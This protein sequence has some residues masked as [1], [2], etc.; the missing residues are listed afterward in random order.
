M[1][2]FFLVKAALLPMP[3]YAAGL[4]FGMPAWG[5]A[6]GLAYGLAWALWRHRGAWPPVFE[7]AQLVG[8]ALVLGVHLA[9]LTAVTPF[10]NAIVLGALAVGSWWS[11]AIDRP[12]TAGFSISD[13]AAVSASPIF[14]MVNRRISWLWAVLF[15]WFALASA[16]KLPGAFHYGPLVFGGLATAILQKVLVRRALTRLA[17]DAQCNAWPAPAFD[18]PAIPGP[19]EGETCD[20]AVVGAG[21][22]GLTAAALLARAGLRVNVYEQHVAA[23]GFCHGWLRRARD[24]QTGQRLLFRFDSGV[25]DVSGWYK[26]G[27]VHTLFLRLG[28]AGDSQWSRVHHRYLIDG[29]SLDI[30][31]DWHAYAAALGARLPQDAAGIAALFEDVHQIHAAMF[32][33]GRDRSGIPGMP[34]TPEA[35]MAFARAHPKA[36]AWMRRPWNDLVASYVSSDVARRWISALAG[37]VTDDAGQLTVADMVPIFGYYFHGGFYPQGGSG[38][39][40]DS[41]VRCIEA[42]GGKVSLRTAVA[43]IRIEDKAAAGLV[44]ADHLGKRR[45]I[46]AKAVICNADLSIMRDRLIH[47]DEARRAISAQTGAL[48]PACSAF[49]LH[50]GIRGQ[51]D[52]PAAIHVESDQGKI[53]I[54]VPS[55][56]DPGCAPEGYS[57]V[58]LLMLLSYEEAKRWYPSAPSDVA[59]DLDAYRNSADYL[60]AKRRAG[61]ALVAAARE[62]IPDLETR[63]VYRA[64]ASPLTFQRYGWSRAGS[65]Y[66]TQAQNGKVPTRTPVRNLA[67]AGAAT[68]GPGVEAVIISGALAAE[69]LV[70]GLLERPD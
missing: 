9:G 21:L 65:I 3:I 52:L 18:G 61:D 24:P 32:S 51:L 28:I 7:S 59:A 62:A 53:A 6:A 56:L 35:L 42:A 17:A 12:W 25:H 23:G 38:V 69:A 4:W 29:E 10:S 67:L 63:I 46:G 40:T 36:V 45:R 33:T 31:H 68:H 37:Y 20:V 5:A 16:L 50:L 54:V 13:H 44:V 2:T 49:G 19:D 57:T 70:P 27:S 30:P 64:E 41:L 55:M 11:L 22:G 26:G 43:A 34:G 60:D 48:T 1:N 47:D 58:E 8:L 39:I 66:G 15:S 14:A